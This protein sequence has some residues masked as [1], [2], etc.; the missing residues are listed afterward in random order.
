MNQR[1]CA[2]EGCGRNHYCRGYCVG[3]YQQVRRGRA[4]TPIR[5]R[6]RKEP[7]HCSV[8]GCSR[9][10]RA[11]GMCDTHYK[12][13]ARGVDPGEFRP[14]GLDLHAFLA[15]NSREDGEC[16][17]WTGYIERGYGRTVWNGKNARAYRLAFELA[18]GAVPG[19]MVVDHICRNRACIRPEHLQAVSS[20]E[21]SQNRASEG[22]SA[23]GVRGVTLDLRS[24]RW[25]ARVSRCG[26]H[27]FAGSFESIED[28]TA[29]VVAMRLDVHTNNIIDRY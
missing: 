1:T 11:R 27:F 13:Q 2:A 24:G 9:S 22:T 7:Q 12:Q 4:I 15:M 3:H 14:R 29:A 25:R 26:E 6:R 23:S 5:E 18:Y 17:V 20:A 28:A 21:N 10:S 16:R 19:G 8:S